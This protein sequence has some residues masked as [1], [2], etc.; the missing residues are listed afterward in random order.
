MMTTDIE[1]QL[2]DLATACRLLA[3]YG[4]TDLCSGHLT[5]RD[6]ERRG[7]WMKRAKVGLDEIVGPDD[8]VLIDFDGTKL[9][10][11]GGRHNE[12]PI[13]TEIMRARPDI[14]CVGH[15]H[16]YHTQLF[17]ATRD[18][19]R[20]V[21]KEAAW[22]GDLPKFKQTCNHIKTPELGRALAQ[23]W[24]NADGVLMI[25]HGMAFCGTSIRE[26]ALVGIYIEKS[27]KAQI[28]LAKTGLAYDWPTPEDVAA[29][30]A[31]LRSARGVEESWN[32]LVRLA[33]RIGAGAGLVALPESHA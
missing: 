23:T 19:L 6:P 8:F 22:F 32:Y 30:R 20:P 4:H 17:A 16:A 28:D 31:T 26:A 18:P 27:V 25:S 2:A 14:Q 15:T 11:T 13:H 29:K 1:A 7:L 9:A 24:G 21:A 10:G 33:G 12:W 5:W 3:L